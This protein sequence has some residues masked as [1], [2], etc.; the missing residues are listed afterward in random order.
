MQADQINNSD[1]ALSDKIESN[2]LFQS[3]MNEPQRENLYS[4]YSELAKFKENELQTQDSSTKYQFLDEELHPHERHEM[5]VH[6]EPVEEEIAPLPS[7]KAVNSG[8]SEFGELPYD[9]QENVPDLN[10][11]V[12][13]F[14]HVSSQRRIRINGRMYTE[15]TNLERD[16]ALVEI[17]PYGAIFDYQGHLFRLNV[18]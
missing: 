10:I 6:A 3:K 16:L 12:H 7:A 1:P 13:M 9:V 4:V 15:G 11:S 17:T 5:V 8:V 2:L 18:R 14:N